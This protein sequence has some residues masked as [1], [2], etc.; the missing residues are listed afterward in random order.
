MFQR[1]R[2]AKIT[3]KLSKC[4]FAAAEL[5]YLGHHIG[6]SRLLSRKQ[7]VLNLIDFPRSI[8]RKGIQRFLGLDGYF[9]RFI[10]HFFEL[11]RVLSDLLKKMLNLCGMMLV[12]RFV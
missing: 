7:K 5:D 6:L 2:E 9:R 12:R 4:E 1:I 3:L 10:P 11:S 8:N